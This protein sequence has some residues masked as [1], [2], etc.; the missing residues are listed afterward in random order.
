VGGWISSVELVDVSPSR[1]ERL[2][3]REKQTI[4]GADVRS[5]HVHLVWKNN[6]QL[7]ISCT[8]CEAEKIR[9]KRYNWGNIKIGYE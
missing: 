8:G 4:F 5:D 1:W 2:L 6:V 9:L 7:S 3:G